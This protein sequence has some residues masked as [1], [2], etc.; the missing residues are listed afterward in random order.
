MFNDAKWAGLLVAWFSNMPRNKQTLQF[1]EELCKKYPTVKFIKVYPYF[2]WH[3]TVYAGI[4]HLILD[5]K[6]I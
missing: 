3:Y 5:N 1:L 6:M 2:Q 4:M